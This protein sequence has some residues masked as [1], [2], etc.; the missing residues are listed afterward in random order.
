MAGYDERQFIASCTADNADSISAAVSAYLL[1]VFSF[2]LSDKP[3]ARAS[4]TA[5][6]PHI[7]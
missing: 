1:E 6:L 5:N 4:R 3:S 7:V 2:A